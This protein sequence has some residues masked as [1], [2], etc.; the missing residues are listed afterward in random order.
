MITYHA[1]SWGPSP[2]TH[3]QRLTKVGGASMREVCRQ[4]DGRPGFDHWRGSLV[5]IITL[6][7]HLQSLQ[8]TNRLLAGCSPTMGEFVQH[9]CPKL[10]G[11]SEFN[12][13]RR[14]SRLLSHCQPAGALTV[15]QPEGMSHASRW[16][17]T[18]ALLWI[19]TNTNVLPYPLVSVDTFPQRF[20]AAG[21]TWWHIIYPSIA[22]QALVSAVAWG[23]GSTVI[24]DDCRD[25]LT[26]KHSD[27]CNAPVWEWK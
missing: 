25:W 2:A 27:G 16:V 1:S 10:N 17:I 21:K 15:Y 12:H 23:E 4:R 6:M 22:E 20:H 13:W 18:F 8:H 3:R 5:T 7:D 24:T 11:G 9:S 14:G 19:I 26:V